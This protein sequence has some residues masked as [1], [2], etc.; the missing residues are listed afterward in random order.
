M[1]Y[2]SV[3]EAAD[4]LEQNTHYIDGGGWIKVMA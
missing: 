1:S 4:H 2:K 3:E